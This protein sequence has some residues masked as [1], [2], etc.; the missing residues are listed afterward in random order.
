M[1]AQAATP[2]I[3]IPGSIPKDC[4]GSSFTNYDKHKYTIE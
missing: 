3:N 1:T 2:H 4:V